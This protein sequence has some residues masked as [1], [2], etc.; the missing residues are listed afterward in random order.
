VGRN[1]SGYER[2][3]KELLQGDP[4]AVRRYGTTLDPVDRLA[5]ARAGASP[6]LVVRAA[7]SFGFDL[8]ALRNE[9]AFPL[10]VKAS[11]AE[12]IHFTAASG[13]A[14][15]Q[16]ESHRRA[17]ERV[18][19]IVLYAY[20]RVGGHRGDR[21]RLYAAPTRAGGGRLGLLRKRL[22]VVDRTRQGNAVLRWADGLPLVRF[23]EHVAALTEPGPAPDGP[24][25]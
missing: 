19:L 21:W 18:G 17:V 24:A 10:E 4:D 23:L 14:A 7:G 8:V 13:R 3:L 9:F 20:R 2:E 16:L 22:P 5:L 12:T 25:P 11:A 15:E 6:F 1:A